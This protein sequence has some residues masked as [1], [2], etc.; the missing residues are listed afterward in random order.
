MIGSSDD[1]KWKYKREDLLERIKEN[2]NKHEVNFKEAKENYRIAIVETLTQMLETAKENKKVPHV[3]N[4][5]QPVHYLKDYD[6][7]IKM[8]EMAQDDIIELSSSDFSRLVMDE[9]SWS[10]SFNEN[11]LS[12]SNE[13]KVDTQYL[14][15]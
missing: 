1:Q 13:L 11:T 15:D 7:T 10:R 5:K 14:E 12:Y 6:R 2:R 3:I 4:L 8:L 9:W